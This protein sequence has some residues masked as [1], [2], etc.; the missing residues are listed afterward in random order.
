MHPAM[1]TPARIL[2]ATVEN[3]HK[4]PEPKRRPNRPPRPQTVARISEA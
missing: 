3:R 2:R 4:R 1:N